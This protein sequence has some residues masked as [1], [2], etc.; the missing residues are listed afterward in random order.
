MSLAL[1]RDC[2]WQDHPAQRPARC[3]ACGHPRL[4]FHAELA[5]LSIAHIDCD[6]FYAS[7]E[8][9]DRPEIRDKPVIVGGGKRGVVSTCCYIARTFGVRSA[10][11]AFKALE[12]CPQAV[13]I[14]PDMAK[15]AAVGRQ[16]REIMR[17]LTPLVEPLSLDEAF[18]DLTG[19]EKLH[20]AS[21]AETLARFARRIETEI[22]ISVSAGLSY[23]KFL[24]KVASDLDK[25]RGF[26]VIGKAEAEDFLAPRPVAMIW[27]VGKAL[28]DRLIQ[29]GITK[30]GDLRPF[31]ETELMARYGVMGRRLFA[32]ARGRDDRL[33][34]PYQ[35]VKSISNETTLDQ[36]LA[37]PVKLGA[38]LWRL[39]EKVAARAK[40]TGL[41]GHT[42]T[43]KLKTHDFK[44]RSLQVRLPAATQLADAIY[45]A[46]E[47]LLHQAADGKQRFRLIGVGISGLE[48]ASAAPQADLFGADAAKREGAERAM[49]AVRKKFGHQVIQKG[50]G[51][52]R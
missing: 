49:D 38:L 33:V 21:P 41:A 20:R 51:L 40:E 18:L 4:L 30:I 44:G 13:V 17:E 36:D 2:F 24:A 31:E 9:R 52:E 32:F 10:M 26:A 5:E 45:R 22:G 6:A 14:K 39:T 47:P 28:N 34:E 37:D 3:P 42:V 23:C 50:R 46:A 43:L 25:P 35:P 27:G 16:V 1:C 29:D 12:L 19:T 15:Y 48:E 8:K 11:P 7:V